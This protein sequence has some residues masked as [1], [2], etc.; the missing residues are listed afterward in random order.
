MARPPPALA[1]PH[2]GGG[3]TSNNN[4]SRHQTADR[5]AGAGAGASQHHP[6]GFVCADKGC[7]RGI[8]GGQR[9]NR[10]SP[11][12]AATP[13]QPSPGLKLSVRISAPAVTEGVALAAD[14]ADPADAGRA[15]SPAGASP[16]V[17]CRSSACRAARAARL[18][19]MECFALPSWSHNLVGHYHFIQTWER[20]TQ[21]GV[22]CVN[23]YR[24][25]G[26]SREC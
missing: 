11:H 2:A 19:S 24:T 16:P 4:N 9:Q 17:P 13:L 22:Q 18:M 25:R 21:G 14:P 23:V 12:V 8:M 1:T 20:C 3:A 10:Q 26:P 5:C 15:S 7:A 6:G